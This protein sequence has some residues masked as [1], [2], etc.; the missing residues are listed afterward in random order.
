MPTGVY[1]HRPRPAAERF[2]PKVNKDGPTLRPE[3]S[4]CW[5]WTG[6][7]LSDG[8]GTFS[9]GGR[10]R[11]AHV[12]AYILTTG[13][14][15]PPETPLITHLC[16]GI[17]EGCV[18]PD[19]L[20]PDTHRGNMRQMTERGRST[21]GTR[22]GG[23]KLTDDQVIAIRSRYAVGNVSQEEL[24]ADYGVAGS[25][26]CLIVTGKRWRHVAGEYG[27]PP[28][29]RSKGEQHPNTRLTEAMVIELRARYAAGGIGQVALAA[30][31][32]VSQ[33]TINNILL[34]KVWRHV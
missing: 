25:L 33:T 22:H 24:A 19:H 11:Y 31:Y 13:H 23:A 9:Y 27:R 28:T 8:R 5:I 15:P 10:T 14:E 4:P 34:R 1:T 32:G 30:E 26:I 20:V 16:D 21:H 7:R 3:L 6:A 29:R 18:R 2:W 12:V 17:Y